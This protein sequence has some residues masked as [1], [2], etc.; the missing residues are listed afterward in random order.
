MRNA[1][2]VMSSAVFDDMP[3]M[4]FTIDSWRY[5]FEK[6]FGSSYHNQTVI[7]AGGGSL[8]LELRGHTWPHS[9]KLSADLWFHGVIGTVNGLVP[10]AIAASLCDR[11]TFH[12]S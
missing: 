10:L 1:L 5:E 11:M 7:Y 3:T 9:A 6:G 2:E 12:E 4:K 8:T